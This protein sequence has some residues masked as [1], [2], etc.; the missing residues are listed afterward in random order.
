MR[1]WNTR[2][3]LLNYY[4]LASKLV[5]PYQQLPEVLEMVVNTLAIERMSPYGRPGYYWW[6]VKVL[7]DSYQFPTVPLLI[8]YRLGT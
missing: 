8:E 5:A 4:Q 6:H 2:S 1:S 7:V 3:S